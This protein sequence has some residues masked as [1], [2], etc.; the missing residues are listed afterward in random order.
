MGA[1]RRL[2]F[3]SYHIEQKGLLDRIVSEDRLKHHQYSLVWEVYLG[4]ELLDFK[5]FKIIGRWTDT[6]YFMNR[7]I[8]VL[9]RI[10]N[11]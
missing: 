5:P 9:K 11:I 7:N 8:C 3:Y 6:N 4:D 1:E 10:T 2:T